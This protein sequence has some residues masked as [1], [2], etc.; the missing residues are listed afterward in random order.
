LRD[1]E[2]RAADVGQRALHLAVLLEDAES[3]DLR[4]EPLAVLGTIV[5]ANSQQ[6]D[7][8]GF[9]LGDALVTDVDGRRANALYDRAR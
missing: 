7:D 2:D 1:R 3:D 6:D 8:T 9:D 5:R 4:G